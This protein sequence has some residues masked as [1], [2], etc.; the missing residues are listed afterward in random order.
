MWLIIV[1][2]DQTDSAVKSPKLLSDFSIFCKN[3]GH[4]D[5]SG[6][7]EPELQNKN[8]NPHGSINRGQVPFDQCQIDQ[9]SAKSQAGRQKPHGRLIEK[10]SC[11]LAVLSGPLVEIAVSHLGKKLIISAS[12]GVIGPLAEVIDRF[13]GLSTEKSGIRKGEEQLGQDHNNQ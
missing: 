1:R 3:S 2:T 12:D 8:A 10:I 7:A 11:P 4:G 9:A 5:V 13:S 6:L